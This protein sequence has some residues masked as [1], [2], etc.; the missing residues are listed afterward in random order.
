MWYRKEHMQPGRSSS[1]CQ[2]QRGR[3]PEATIGWQ[4]MIQT[5]QTMLECPSSVAKKG[6]SNL[7]VPIHI[8]IYIYATSPP[9]KNN[10]FRQF[11][12]L[13]VRVVFSVDGPSRPPSIPKNKVIHLFL[14]ARK[15]KLI[16]NNSWPPIL[17][18][19]NWWGYRLAYI[20]ILDG[21][22]I[23]ENFSCTI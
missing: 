12:C 10:V 20:T 6:T 18:Y 14:A 19:I 1:D 22:Y 5:S 9:K 4:T 17:I 11:F 13:Y 2:A 8:Y 16:S 3:R 23:I 15:Y 21:F 7:Q